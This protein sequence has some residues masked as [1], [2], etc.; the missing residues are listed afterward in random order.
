MRTEL[1]TI[2]YLAGTLS[3]T[4]RAGFKTDSVRSVSRSCPFRSAST[5]FLNSITR[6]FFLRRSFN[7]TP[8]TISSKSTKS[9]WCLAP[10]SQSSSNFVLHLKSLCANLRDLSAAM[11]RSNLTYH[12]NGLFREP[13]RNLFSLSTTYGT[14]FFWYSI[15]NIFRISKYDFPSPHFIIGSFFKALLINPIAFFSRLPS[16]FFENKL[17][18][19]QI[20]FHAESRGDSI[21]RELLLQPK[22]SL[23]ELDKPP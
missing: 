3:A 4:I 13:E 12:V 19:L 8:S 1:H 15:Q 10:E 9:L 18:H 16:G 5:S 6:F 23:R 21:R 7:R 22:Y 14:S 2:V 20:D 17:H 11:S